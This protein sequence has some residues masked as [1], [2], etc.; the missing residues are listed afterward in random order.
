MFVS[1]DGSRTSVLAPLLAV[2]VAMVRRPFMRGID[3]SSNIT[4]GA[5]GS[6]IRW[7]VEGDEST[8]DHFTVF[9]SQD[10]ENLMLLA[11]VAIGQHSLDLGR[12]GLDPADYTGVCEDRGQTITHQ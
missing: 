5:H 1:S 8:L 2:T 4:A 11:N 10:G 7:N 6:Q 3:I 12:F 9:V